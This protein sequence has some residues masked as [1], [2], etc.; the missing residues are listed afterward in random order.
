MSISRLVP[1]LINY[2]TGKEYKRGDYSKYPE[3]QDY[4]R[5]II[6]DYLNDREKEFEIF[7]DPFDSTIKEENKKYEINNAIDDF[8]KF[9]KEAEIHSDILKSE[10]KSS[11]NI[12]LKNIK[13]LVDFE[14]FILDFA[15]IT[16]KRLQKIEDELNIY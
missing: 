11:N 12:N 10:I 9:L 5:P 4:Y 7:G 1:K 2:I 16:E 3:L 6:L 15:T 8:H 13:E 14:Q